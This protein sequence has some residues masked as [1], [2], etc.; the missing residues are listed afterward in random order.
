M[1]SPV[2][3]SDYFPLNNHLKGK[4]KV[5]GAEMLKWSVILSYLK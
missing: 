2:Y 5:T 1:H 3:P 4:L